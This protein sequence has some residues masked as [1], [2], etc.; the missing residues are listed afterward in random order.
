MVFSIFASCE[1]ENYP[2]FIKGPNKVAFSIIIDGSGSMSD[3]L[4]D[5]KI[6]LLSL[7]NAMEDEDFM[8]FIITGASP[9]I[10]KEWTNDKN[11]ISVSI[12][13]LI[14]GGDQECYELAIEL[15]VENAYPDKLNCILL[16]V[17][18]TF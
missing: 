7:A 15:A 18:S 10:W 17:I 2:Y 14:A 12:D 1:N 9:Y 6:A 5:V 13:E 3:P 11:D 4:P 16:I 8:Q